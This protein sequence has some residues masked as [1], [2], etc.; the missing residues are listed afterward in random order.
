MVKSVL[1]RQSKLR[2]QRKKLGQRRREF[3][4]TDEEYAHMKE[5]L[6]H[7]RSAFNQ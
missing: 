6:K 4:L 2:K 3:F 7:L 5:Y 1:E